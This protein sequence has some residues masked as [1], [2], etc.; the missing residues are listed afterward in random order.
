[1]SV[2]RYAGILSAVGI[3][4]AD[5]VVEGNEPVGKSVTSED[6]TSLES[7][8]LGRFAT[9]SKELGSKLESEGSY[10]SIKFEK[11]LNIRYSGTDCGLMVRSDIPSLQSFCDKFQVEYSRQFGF[12]L[13]RELVVD[14]IRV[15]AVGSNAIR[16]GRAAARSS[17]NG[18]PSS[19]VNAHFDGGMMKTTVVDCVEGTYPGPCLILDDLS[20]IVVEPGWLATV[21]GEDVKLEHVEKTRNKV[22]KLATGGGDTVV[23]LDS[24][25]LSVFSHRFMSIAEQMGRILQRTSVSTNIKERL[26]FSCAIFGPDGGLVSNGKFVF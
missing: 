4:L 10:S 6:L 7:H 16:P 19:T 1:M 17:T 15:R 2:P 14:D 5:V 21:S 25:V 24:I 3:F 11:Y 23:E 26:D 20:T 12:Q 9:L 13:E 22:E 8:V 18:V